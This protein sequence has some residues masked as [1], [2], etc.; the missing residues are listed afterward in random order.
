MRAAEQ[1]V[2][3][4]ACV[5]EHILSGLGNRADNINSRHNG[6]KSRSMKGSAT[7]PR[8]PEKKK[9][10]G[11]RRGRKRVSG[12]RPSQEL[13]ISEYRRG[14]SAEWSPR[15]MRTERDAHVSGEGKKAGPIDSA[16]HIRELG[17]EG[18][19]LPRPSAK[20]QRT[21]WTP[22]RER[23]LRRR[24]STRERSC[25]LFGRQG[26]VDLQNRKIYETQACSAFGAP[27][28]AP[29]GKLR[30]GCCVENPG[31]VVGKH[32]PWRSGALLPSHRSYPAP[33]VCLGLG[34]GVYSLNTRTAMDLDGPSRVPQAKLRVVREEE[35]RRR[36][37]CLADLKA[38]TASP[39]SKPVPEGMTRL[40][41]GMTRLNTI[42]VHVNLVKSPLGLNPCKH[43]VEE[44]S[45]NTQDR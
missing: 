8:R 44:G 13:S 5:R 20:Q 16:G 29:L 17:E 33:R 24:I 39:T 15:E 28:R 36:E 27:P 37:D 38:R 31:S 1:V 23:D 10:P 35:A 34:I 6:P 30:K 41:T 32:R 19:G 42:E 7:R 11:P 25:Y 40:N 4:P 45:S 18:S 21:T 3:G 22:P 43:R 26:F 2:D 9:K 14:R 12:A